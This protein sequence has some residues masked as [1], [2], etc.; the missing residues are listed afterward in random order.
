MATLD[1]EWNDRNTGFGM[2]MIARLKPGVRLQ[3]AQGD[4]D[5]VAREMNPAGAKDTTRP[6]V[7]SL[8][9]YFIGDVSTI[10]W[11]LLGAVGVVLLI[12]VA[13]VANLFLARGQDR[14]KS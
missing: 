13:N 8:Q 9:S 10:L 6:E 3:E 12:A 2:R 14:Q 11:V 7:R 5:R 1:V 4:L